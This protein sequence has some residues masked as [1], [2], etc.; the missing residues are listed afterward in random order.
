MPQQGNLSVA[1]VRAGGR[2]YPLVSERT[3]KTCC[4]EYRGVIERDAVAGRT[5]KA[6]VRSLPDGA[7]LT[8]RNLSDHWRNKHVPVAAEAVQVLAERQSR[9]RGEIVEVAAEKIV[10]YLG[11]AQLIVGRVNEKIATGE[12]E[13]DVRDALRATELL[14][15]F[16]PGPSMDEGSYLEG[17]MIF[18]NIAKEIMT[19][20]QSQEFGRR[21]AADITLQQLAQRW[22]EL[23]AQRDAL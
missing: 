19:A 16:D 23:A 9:D 2:E 20:E 10:D 14:A 17:F 21:L 1:V 13:P 8:E 5:W 4:S 7:D 11:F 22:D 6:I 3:C 12:L 15:R 18:H